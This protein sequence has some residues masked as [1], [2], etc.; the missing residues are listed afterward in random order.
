M[1]KEKN[2][3]QENATGT[4]VLPEF[5]KGIP[6]AK[7]RSRERRALIVKYYSNLW[8]KL[9]KEGRKNMIF[10]DFLGV[11]I[12]IVENESNKKT[13]N[14]ASMNW[15]S[16]YA[17]QHLEEVVKNAC[18]DES[19]PVYEKAKKGT[20]TKNGYKNMAILYYFFVDTNKQYLNFKVKLTIGIR[21]DK[22]HVQYCINK[23]ETK[24]KSQPYQASTPQQ[25]PHTE[26]AFSDCKNTTNF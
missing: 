13:V 15:Q 4:G 24:E 23:I 21:A 2:T 19:Q 8:K 9:Q 7:H 25:G 11:N 22:K 5:I 16:T 10:N 1:K 18:G 3:I 20:Q 17:I 12:F 14:T 6:T 26:L